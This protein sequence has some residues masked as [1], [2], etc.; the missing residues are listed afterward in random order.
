MQV[1][2]G[3]M[4]TS[5]STGALRALAMAARL[6]TARPPDARGSRQVRRTHS[7]R[8]SSQILQCRVGGRRQAR[9]G[10]SHIVSEP[11]PLRKALGRYAANWG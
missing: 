6:Q 7:G 10:R 3:R 4:Q 1:Q 2:S 8:S 5:L 11:V 9:I